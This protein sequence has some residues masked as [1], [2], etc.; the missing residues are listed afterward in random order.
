MSSSVTPP[1]R[2]AT[3]RREQHGESWSAWLSAGWELVCGSCAAV[4]GRLFMPF[5]G[6]H[7]LA[8]SSS[9]LDPRIVERDGPETVTGH[10]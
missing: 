10:G 3:L 5:S 9:T 2:C 8:G 7:I 1:Y 6:G 4:I